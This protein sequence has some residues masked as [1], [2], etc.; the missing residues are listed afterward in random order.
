MEVVTLWLAVDDSTVKNGC[1]SVLPGTHGMDLAGLVQAE[2]ESVLGSQTPPEL[3]AE[4][5]GSAVDLVLKAGDVS[6]H[7]PKIV[8]GETGCLAAWLPGCLP[9]RPAGWLPA[10]LVA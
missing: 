10:C 3:I 1:M 5:E 8:H 4:H 9:G 2:G 6:V 7:N